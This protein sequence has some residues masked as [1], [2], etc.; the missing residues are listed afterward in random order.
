MQILSQKTMY[1]LEKGVD[2]TDKDLIE[3]DK[4]YHDFYLTKE[5]KEKFMKKHKF[6]NATQQFAAFIAK[7]GKQYAQIEFERKSK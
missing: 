2:F 3:T 4:M 1:L 7:D 5:F 6:T